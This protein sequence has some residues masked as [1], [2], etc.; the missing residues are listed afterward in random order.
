MSSPSHQPGL[1]FLGR[2]VPTVREGPEDGPEGV[3]AV[4]SSSESSSSSGL[5]PSSAAEALEDA[6]KP[7]ET[8]PAPAL[9][10]ESRRRSS[11]SDIA[12]SAIDSAG[13]GNMVICSMIGQGG[14]W[15]F[16]LGLE[17]GGFETAVGLGFEQAGQN[18]L[19]FALSSGVR[20][21]R[22]LG[23]ELLEPELAI[24]AL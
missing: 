20:R 9:P 4:D 11:S 16:P 15:D 7:L 18:R 1:G 24:L 14:F 23:L 6:L 22:V 19:G 17:P 5:A 3:R 2:A 21:E 12:V 10:A 8:V 13:I